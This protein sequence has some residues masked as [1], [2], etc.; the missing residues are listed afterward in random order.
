MALVGITRSHGV[1]VLQNVWISYLFLLLLRVTVSLHGY[2][3]GIAGSAVTL[4]YSSVH[5]LRVVLKAGD[6]LL[7]CL[8]LKAD[9]IHRGKQWKLV[10]QVSLF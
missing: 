4:V 3:G 7:N 8:A 6:K 1:Q 10:N 2:G 9:L 5:V